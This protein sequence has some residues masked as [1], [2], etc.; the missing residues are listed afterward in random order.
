M[1]FN[2]QTPLLMSYPTIEEISPIVWRFG[3]FNVNLRQ[4]FTAEKRTRAPLYDFARK[5]F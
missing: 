5:I 1:F 3:F 2:I 4:Q